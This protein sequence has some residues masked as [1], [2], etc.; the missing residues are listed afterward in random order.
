VIWLRGYDDSYAK[1]RTVTGVTQLRSL[2]RLVGGMSSDC[3]LYSL[4]IQRNQR[5][6]SNNAV[7][8]VTEQRNPSN[9]A[10]GNAFPRCPVAHNAR[11]AAAPTASWATVFSRHDH[12]DYCTDIQYS[13]QPA[14]GPL[15]AP[16]PSARYTT[17]QAS[18]RQ[19]HC[20]SINNRNLAWSIAGLAKSGARFVHCV[21]W[22]RH[23]CPGPPTAKS[24]RRRCTSRT[25]TVFAPV[26]VPHGPWFARRHGA[27]S[28]SFW[29]TAIGR[30][31]SQQT[32][33]LGT[34]PSTPLLP[35]I[36]HFWPI[37]SLPL[38]SSRANVTLRRL[39]WRYQRACDTTLTH[40]SGKF[41]CARSFHVA[42]QF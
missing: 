27:D 14:G 3:F 42:A 23:P 24:G 7:P 2:C 40:S 20:F 6:R 13:K 36:V 22:P 35:G 28:I 16:L 41:S 39:F 38:F 30:S 18:W 11:G 19:I 37:F 34:A 26:L 5:N 25:K 15:A 29:M 4:L 9:S 8:S 32:A 17:L 10:A 33:R 12:Q 21:V 31:A 1:P